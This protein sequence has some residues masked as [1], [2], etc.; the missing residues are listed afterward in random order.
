MRCYDG[1][2]CLPCLSAREVG[3]ASK[4]NA[5]FLGEVYRDVRARICSLLQWTTSLDVDNAVSSD[6][7]RR[8][9]GRTA[10]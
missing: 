2:S 7:R 10:V 8:R 6:E 4:R 5:A 3:R 1:A 9:Y